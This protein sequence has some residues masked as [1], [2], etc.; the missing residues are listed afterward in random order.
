MVIY[1]KYFLK[2]K[3]DGI[4]DIPLTDSSDDMKVIF[5]GT[6]NTLG[7]VCRL[8]QSILLYAAGE[9]FLVDC[10][11]G[12]VQRMLAKSISPSIINKIFFTHHHIDH[13]G[14]FIDYFIT[15]SLK[16][17]DSG[18][19]LPVEIYGPDNSKEIIFKMRESVE[20]DI[21]SRHS[22][23]DRWSKIIIKELNNGEIYNKNGLTVN[24]FTVDHGPYKPGV[25]Y[26]FEY[27]EK[28]IVFS[29]DTLPHE[30]V[31]RSAENADILI[32]ESYNKDWIH[33]L[34]ARNPASEGELNSVTLKHSSTIE[35]AKIAK[36][37][38]VKHLVLTHHIPSPLPIKKIEQQYIKGMSKIFNGKITVARDLMEVF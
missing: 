21:S 18:R 16:R 2:N 11:C 6:G 37:A 31:C 34:I 28:K 29:G 20:S 32:H 17:S 9:F 26:K 19:I 5:L 7:G 8:K 24:V 36:A 14:G 22:S 23:D 27:K 1:N 13:N 12:A 30:N 10:G 25:G 15:S 33:A 4:F 3:L 35:V 38:G